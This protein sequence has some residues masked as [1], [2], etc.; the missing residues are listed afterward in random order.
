MATGKDQPQRIIL[1]M[2]VDLLF[3]LDAGRAFQL[4]G[5]LP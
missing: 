4:V 5:R 2:V 3:G 1:D